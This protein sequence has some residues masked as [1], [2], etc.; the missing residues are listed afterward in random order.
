MCGALRTA[1]AVMAEIRH[2][3]NRLADSS[4]FVKYFVMQSIVLTLTGSWRR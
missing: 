3:K 1:N 2:L 4:C